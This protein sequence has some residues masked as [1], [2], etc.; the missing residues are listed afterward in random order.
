MIS[1]TVK[2]VLSSVASTVTGLPAFNASEGRRT[3]ADALPEMKMVSSELNQVFNKSSLGGAGIALK[4]QE[5]RN[6]MTV[7]DFS[8]ALDEGRLRPVD[9]RAGGSTPLPSCRWRR[10]RRSGGVYY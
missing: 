7:R 9:G 6:S 5:I 10:F 3:V 1:S 2:P 4:G 8:R